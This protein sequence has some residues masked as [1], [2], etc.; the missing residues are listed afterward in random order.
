MKIG[1]FSD[2]YRPQINGVSTVLL[3]LERVFGRMGHQVYLFV[4]AYASR[5]ASSSGN[6]FRFP[7][8]PVL[9][10]KESRFA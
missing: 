3:T 6:V 9:Y 8:L 10:R 1:F 2:T 4:P 7:A 5:R